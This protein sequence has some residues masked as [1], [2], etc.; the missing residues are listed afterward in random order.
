MRVNVIVPLLAVTVLGAPFQ[1]SNR[2]EPTIFSNLKTQL[3]ILYLPNLKHNAL[4]DELNKRAV[5]EIPGFYS[6]EALVASDT[7]HA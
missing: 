7:T 5:T 3:K 4:Q 6:A 1:A 2:N